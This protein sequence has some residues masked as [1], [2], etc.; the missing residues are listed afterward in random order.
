MGRQDLPPKPDR[1]DRLI[2]EHV[3]DLAWDGE[4]TQHFDEVGH[5]AR[6]TWHRD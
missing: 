5:F 6:V 1:R 3:H 2:R 4:M